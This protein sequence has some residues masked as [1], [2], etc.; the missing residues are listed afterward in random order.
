M[1]PENVALFG[2][3]LIL[4]AFLIV[5]LAAVMGRINDKIERRKRTHNDTAYCRRRLERESVFCR[6]QAD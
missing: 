5:L 3:G 6:K 2:L 1:H 4:A